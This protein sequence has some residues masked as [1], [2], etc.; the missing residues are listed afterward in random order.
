MLQIMKSYASACCGAI[1]G[2]VSSAGR[3]R[4]WKFTINNFEAIPAK[5]TKKISLLSV[6]AATLTCIPI[7]CNNRD[8]NRPSFASARTTQRGCAQSQDTLGRAYLKYLHYVQLL[9][10]FLSCPGGIFLPEMSR[11][12]SNPTF[13]N[14][15]DTWQAN[16][17]CPATAPNAISA[18]RSAYS[19]STCP[20]VF[21]HTRI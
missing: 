5:T 12:N 13:S 1:I 11:S 9:L 21:F 7:S 10:H 18:R 19:T 14:A 2:D 15:Q 3:G 8:P 16:I 20:S 17:R 6:R 4:T